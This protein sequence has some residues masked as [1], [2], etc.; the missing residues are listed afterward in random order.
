MKK[1]LSEY[2]LLQGPQPRTSELR[3]ALRIFRECIRGFR[4]LH[5]VGPCAT[6]FG[7]ARFTEGHPFYQL[8]RRLGAELASAGFTVMTGGGPG[9]ME[10]ANRGAKDVNGKSVGCNISLPHEQKPNVYL[11][12]WLEFHYFFVRKLMLAKYSYA[13]IAMPGGYGTLDEFFEV[14]TLIQ[15][16]KLKDF[17]LVLMGKE[18]WAPL[19][20]FLE[21]TLKRWQTIDPI[22]VD[23]VLV[24][25]S[26]EEVVRFIVDKG[27]K[28]FGLTYGQRLKRRWYLFER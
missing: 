4:A 7:S 10:A 3:R 19:M 25:D 22:D 8:T 1:T 17:P 13:F 24:S 11:D 2:S 18:Y 14:A 15:T 20:G 6:V 12:K 16:E 28:N 9:L 26:P 5:F 27:T 23:R 21:S